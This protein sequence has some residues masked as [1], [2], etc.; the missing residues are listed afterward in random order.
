MICTVIYILRFGEGGQGG[1]GQ[2]RDKYGKDWCYN[3]SLAV[4]QKTIFKFFCENV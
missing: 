2:Q 3:L 4:R 1:S